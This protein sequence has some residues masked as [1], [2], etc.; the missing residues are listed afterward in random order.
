MHL[1]VYAGTE[2]AHRIPNSARTSNRRRHHRHCH[3]RLRRVTVAAHGQHR[4]HRNIPPRVQLG[5]CCHPHLN[6]PAV[7][8]PAAACHGRRRLEQRPGQHSTCLRTKA[9]QVRWMVL[10]LSWP[11]LLLV[12]CLSKAYCRLPP[13]LQTRALSSSP[14]DKAP[15]KL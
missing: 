11:A 5:K 4:H 12:A 9:R 3:R 8:C 10:A 6:H 15:S 14:N 7:F 13:A 2:A 1:Y